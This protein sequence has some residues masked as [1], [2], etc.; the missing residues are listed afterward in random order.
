LPDSEIAVG[1]HSSILNQR[2]RAVSA[3]DRPSSRTAQC[4]SSV[5]TKYEDITNH[6]KSSQKKLVLLNLRPAA[7]SLLISAARVPE[8]PHRLCKPRR[9]SV[10]TFCRAF[11]PGTRL[12]RI[13]DK[14]MRRRRARGLGLG[15]KP[16]CLPWFSGWTRQ[17]R[18][19]LQA[20]CF[21]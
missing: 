3:D 16:P 1:H 21:V 2:R 6:S 11:P 17:A 13:W 15:L 7:C 4:E 18:P 9:I 10:D 5:S 19:S 20:C 12:S 14:C 8:L